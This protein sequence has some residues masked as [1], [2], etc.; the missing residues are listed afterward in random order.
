MKRWILL[1]VLCL[2]LLFT[3][4]DGGKR[5][6]VTPTPNPIPVSETQEKPWYGIYAVTDYWNEG[7][8]AMS[9][10]DAEA[11]LGMELRYAADTLSWNDQICQ[12]PEYAVSC[13]SSKD[14][15]QGFNG[16]LEAKDLG[17]EGNEV[18]SVD[19]GNCDFF[20]G[21]FTIVDEYTIAIPY[22]GVYFIATKSV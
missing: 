11:Y 9:D 19:V 12:S 10:E 7:M 15:S 5:A 21:S 14:F 1:T 4:C 8:S 3:G 20:G 22:D 2:M 18:H 13:M 16:Y 17:I 6:E